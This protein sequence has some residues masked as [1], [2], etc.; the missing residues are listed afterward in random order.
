MKLNLKI[1]KTRPEVSDEELRSYMDF[2]ALLERRRLAL[3]KAGRLNMLRN[4]AILTI[5]VILLSVVWYTHRV[6]SVGKI[7]EEGVPEESTSPENRPAPMAPV[8][9]ATTA[10]DVSDANTVN[11]NSAAKEQ[12]PATP[13]PETIDPAPET[14]DKEK[15]V[16]N[17]QEPEPET[18]NESGYTYTE[19]TPVDGF[20]A[21][22]EYF[23]R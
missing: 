2:D 7:Q 5:T 3:Q 12:Q 13:A 19:A 6:N 16:D 10:H 21:L 18:A 4:G 8:D 17:G 1:M 23:N 9:T 22:Y 15:E 11:P 20:P 14:I